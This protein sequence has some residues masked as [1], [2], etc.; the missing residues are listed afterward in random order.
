MVEILTDDAVKGIEGVAGISAYGKK[1]TKLFA[2][3][4]LSSTIRIIF[5]SKIS[6]TLF[7]LFWLIKDII[8]IHQYTKKPLSP[9]TAER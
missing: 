8:S 1:A 3:F 9:G 2:D 7:S 5:M 6:A 4:L